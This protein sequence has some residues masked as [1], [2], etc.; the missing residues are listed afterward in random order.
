MTSLPLPLPQ[1]ESDRLEHRKNM[2]GLLLQH[3]LL[4]ERRGDTQIMMMPCHLQV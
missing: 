2:M 1:E 3:L 4:Q